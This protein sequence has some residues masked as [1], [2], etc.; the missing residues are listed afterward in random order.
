MCREMRREPAWVA[1]IRCAMLT[2]TVTVEAVMREAN[3]VAGREQTVEDI[4]GKMADRGLL[5]ESPGDPS[6]YLPGPVLLDSDRQHL[7]FERASDGG[8]HRWRSTG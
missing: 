2:G 4:L 5:R 8:A 3:L 7:D 1:A 6:R